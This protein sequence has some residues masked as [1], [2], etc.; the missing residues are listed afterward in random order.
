VSDNGAYESEMKDVALFESALRAAVPTRPD[1]SLGRTL[2]PRLAAAA[3][4]STVPTETRTVGRPRSRRALVA[5]AGIAVA[6]IPLVLAGL[7]V[8]GVT[9]PKPAR[10]AFDEIGISLPNQPAGHTHKSAVQQGPGQSAGNVG[11]E[12]G[13]SATP[14]KG[15]SAPAHQHALKQR[16]KARGKAVGHQRGKAIGLTGST[17]PGQSGQTGP[18]SHSNA[19]GS[20]GSHSQGPPSSPKPHPTPVPQGNANPQGNAKGQQK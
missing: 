7:A 5:R 1:P 14:A 16:Q 12:T 4:A 19:G 8:A 10:S 15:N 13:S 6:L 11:T 18:P 2:V 9:V 3:R 20:S 17:P